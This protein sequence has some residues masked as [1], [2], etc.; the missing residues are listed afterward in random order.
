L[1]G[2]HFQ[3]QLSF[4]L[5]KSVDDDSKF[6]P[7]FSLLPVDLYTV[8]LPL[9]GAFNRHTIK[10][11]LALQ[12]SKGVNQSPPQFEL[13]VQVRASSPSSTAAAPDSITST[14]TNV[15][16][17]S[18]PVT[19]STIG[20]RTTGN[21]SDDRAQ[22]ASLDVAPEKKTPPLPSVSDGSVDKLSLS[23]EKSL[24]STNPLSLS[25]RMKIS[26][27]VSNGS[28]GKL[29]L[30]F[31][32][33]VTSTNPLSLSP[34]NKTE[35][36]ENAQELKGRGQVR[37]SL[38]VAE[39]IGPRTKTGQF[40]LEALHR[41]PVTN[42]TNTAIDSGEGV[43]AAF[44]HVNNKSRRG[45]ACVQRRKDRRALK[46]ALPDIA[47]QTAPSLNGTMHVQQ[48]RSART[49]ASL[50][51][52][53]H[54][55]Q[56]ER[57]DESS[58]AAAVK[59]TMTNGNAVVVREGGKAEVV[60]ESMEQAR[61]EAEEQACKEAEE[62]AHKEAEEQAHK[63]AQEQARMD[64][65]EQ[66]RKEAEEQARKEAEEQAHKETEEQARKVAQE[67]AK[68]EAVK[69]AC[70]D[71]E[72][73]PRKE[74]DEQ[75][76][77]EAQEQ[78]RK[79]AEEQAGLGVKVQARKEAEGQGSLWA[80]TGGA[81][82]SASSS[83]TGAAIRSTIS[84]LDVVIGTK[85]NVKGGSRLFRG[86]IRPLLQSHPD[87]HR[88]CLLAFKGNNSAP[89]KNVLLSLRAQ[90][91]RENALGLPASSLPIQTSVHSRPLLPAASQPQPQAAASLPLPCTQ[92]TFEN[93]FNAKKCEM[94]L[95]PLQKRRSARDH[96]EV[97]IQVLAT[98]S[99]KSVGAGHRNLLRVLRSRVHQK[100]SNNS[101][102]SMP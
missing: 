89:S 88:Q 26:P 47:A 61:K 7:V 67:Q 40:A 83:D 97:S 68:Q 30:T 81:P 48:V 73:Q 80:E 79:D 23:V 55:Q 98:G 34:R 52:A 45:V 10:L 6:E 54:V 93:V 25:T 20:D 56:D 78:A 41:A 35:N 84:L 100:E 51:G 50:N 8:L 43:N 82:A 86:A 4:T 3:V 28:V 18:A 58:Q 9:Y 14:P 62:Q 16:N 65:E 38:H 69:Q 46:A 94:C 87:Q 29:G 74:A 63:E 1:V 96:A 91:E 44:G 19:A 33:S 75:A 90:L 5:Q 27:S 49:A 32:K 36:A 21:S 60:G 59:V 101:L 70:I 102:P 11:A 37:Y 2:R 12:C 71:A 42:S 92:C 95:R 66:A 85:T 72:E 77:L 39:E 24:T 64:A 15:P 57:S 22:T 13:V 53:Q 31:E 99:P 17:G 76:R